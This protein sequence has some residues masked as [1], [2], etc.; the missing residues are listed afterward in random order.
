MNEPFGF[1]STGRPFIRSVADPLPTEPK[2]KFESR[3]AICDPA[4]G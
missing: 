1:T 4:G 2:M 3:V